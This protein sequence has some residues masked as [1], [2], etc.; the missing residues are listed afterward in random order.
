MQVPRRIYWTNGEG[1]YEVKSL[2]NG[3]NCVFCATDGTNLT[4]HP[5]KTVKRQGPPDKISLNFH[6]ETTDQ[7]TFLKGS[8][9]IC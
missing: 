1:T 6:K 5:D 2:N 3:G 7:R 9:G 8:Q 4:V